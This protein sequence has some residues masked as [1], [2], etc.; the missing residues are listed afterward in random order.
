[1]TIHFIGTS[2][3]LPVQSLLAKQGRD[4]GM[5]WHFANNT[6]YQEGDFLWTPEGLSHTAESVVSRWEKSSGFKTIPIQSGD[7]VVA[8]G[9]DDRFD[10]YAF[11]A[12]GADH[13]SS[14]CRSQA[15]R[16]LVAAS[17]A[18]RAVKLI[19]ENRPEAATIVV[20]PPLLSLG[21]QTKK[22]VEGGVLK[23][24]FQELCENCEIA[25]K[26]QNARYLMQPRSTL[27]FDGAYVYTQD[28]HLASDGYHWGEAGIE[29]LNKDLLPALGL[30]I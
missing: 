18:L 3:I 12:G 25:A 1:M 23:A 20:E 21:E 15:L 14:A 19:R 6:N 8:L 24:R 22:F 9:F 5:L 28:E 27:L 26:A 30:P 17:P 2:H 16:D 4:E 7:Q 11:L 29:V 10:R 13:V